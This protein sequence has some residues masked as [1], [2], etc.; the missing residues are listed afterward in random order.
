MPNHG[1]K[2]ATQERKK[3]IKVKSTND[4]QSTTQ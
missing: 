3:E 1:T 2:Q 4:N